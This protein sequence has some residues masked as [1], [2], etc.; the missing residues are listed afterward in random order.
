MTG[1]RQMMIPLNVPK[2]FPFGASTASLA[3]PFGE[4]AERSEAD[5]V[6]LCLPSRPSPAALVP[7]PE[8]TS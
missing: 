7:I 4:G 3:F 6:L 8:V 5:E 2:T 1:T